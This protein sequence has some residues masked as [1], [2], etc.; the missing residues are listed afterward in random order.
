MRFVRLFV[1]SLV[2]RQLTWDADGYE[3]P[4]CAYADMPRV[5]AR[6]VQFFLF[7]F[8]SFSLRVY[9]RNQGIEAPQPHLHALHS[10]YLS[11]SPSL[12]A[13]LRATISRHTGDGTGR[14]A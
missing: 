6:D 10:I 1:R 2:D 14:R 4:N 7:L 13:F 12:T 9:A 11:L 5:Y 8:L 3:Y